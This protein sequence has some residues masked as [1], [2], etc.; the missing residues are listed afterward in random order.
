MILK[1]LEEFCR[2]GAPDQTKEGAVTVIDHQRRRAV[3]PVRSGPVTV[4]RQSEVQHGDVPQTLKT[5]EQALRGA[6][7][8][9]LSSRG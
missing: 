4:I 9:G 2:C 1:A 7:A 5:P 8:L 6:P 3:D